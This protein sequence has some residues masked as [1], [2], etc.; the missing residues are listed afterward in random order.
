MGIASSPMAKLF[1]KKRTLT[2]LTDN[3]SVRNLNGGE[4]DKFDRTFVQKY[5]DK[6]ARY[7]GMGTS[8]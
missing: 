6:F 7:I 5:R 2:I 4:R 3:P 1:F 8:F